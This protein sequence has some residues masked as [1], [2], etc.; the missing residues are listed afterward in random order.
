MGKSSWA[1]RLAGFPHAL[2]EVNHVGPELEAATLQEPEVWATGRFLRGCGLGL[3]GGFVVRVG[4]TAWCGFGW[5]WG[6]SGFGLGLYSA[7]GASCGL[8]GASA[9]AYLTGPPPSSESP[10]VWRATTLLTGCPEPPAVGSRLGSP[11][12]SRPGWSPSSDWVSGTSG[13]SPKIAPTKAAASNVLWS[14]C[15]L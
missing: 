12:R 3:G 13:K 14:P 4:L 8:P 6:L 9:A 10:Q 2:P 11:W 5:V 7:S 1:L 15:C